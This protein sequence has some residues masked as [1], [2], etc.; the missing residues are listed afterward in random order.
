M[1]LADQASEGLPF[2]QHL[3]IVKECVHICSYLWDKV[4]VS[5]NIKSVSYQL[6]WY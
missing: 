1:E 3:P 6:F 4:L 5:Y 2:H